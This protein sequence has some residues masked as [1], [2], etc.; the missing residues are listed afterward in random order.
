MRSIVL[1]SGATHG[2]LM[3]KDELLPTDLASCVF[4][5]KGYVKN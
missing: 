4:S 3:L 1:P 5:N 2:L